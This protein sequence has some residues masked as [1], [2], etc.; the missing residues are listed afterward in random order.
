MYIWFI[1]GSVSSMN[2][3]VLSVSWPSGGSIVSLAAFGTI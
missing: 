3:V 1:G 2:L